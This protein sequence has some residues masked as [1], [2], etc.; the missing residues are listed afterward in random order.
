[1]KKLIK[2]TLLLLASAVVFF[3][4]AC[5]SPNEKTGEK[6][7]ESVTG[8]D[9]EMNEAGDV[10]IEGNGQ[11]VVLNQ[12]ANTWPAD[13]PSE[14]PQLQNL[15]IQRVTRSEMEGTITWSVVYEGASIDML[16]TY[17][18]ALKAKGFKTTL[19]QTP[20]GGNVIVEKDGLLV[21][22]MVSQKACMISVQQQAK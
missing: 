15:A 18:A 1:M 5:K 3:L 7:L 17:N 16:K 8:K 12:Q 10:T 21:S 11:R 22:C 20:Q 13:I 2:P 4:A 9:I 6:A 19:T 14:V